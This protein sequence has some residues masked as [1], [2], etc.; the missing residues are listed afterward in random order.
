MKAEAS[1]ITTR[2]QRLTGKTKT[3]L[4]TLGWASILYLA[5][6]K[7]GDGEESK[8]LCDVSFPL[9]FLSCLVSLRSHR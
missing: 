7:G 2:G 6:G 1:A 3:N 9:F 5:P 8:M 4:K